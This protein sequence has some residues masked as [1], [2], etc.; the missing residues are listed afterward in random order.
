MKKQI[1][2]TLGAAFALPSVLM[3]AALGQA[4]HRNQRT[5]IFP[6]YFKRPD[7][8]RARFRAWWLRSAPL[9][10]N[11]TTAITHRRSQPVAERSTGTA[12]PSGG[13]HYGPRNAVQR[14]LKHAR[15]PVHHTGVGLS[16]APPSGG[17]QAAL[18]VSLT[19]RP[20]APPSVPSALC[21]CS[22]R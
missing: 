15:G 9:W 14:V 22:P 1:L 17:P 10:E 13:Y 8:T 18:Q 19:I 20:T 6:R 2:L 12:A 4:A 11:P 7:P 21:A 3:L 16:Q 5:L